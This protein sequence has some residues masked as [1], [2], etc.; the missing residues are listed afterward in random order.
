MV[1][2]EEAGI[3]FSVLLAYGIIQMVFIE[4]PTMRY[5]S[6]RLYL[7]MQFIAVLIV[8]SLIAYVSTFGIR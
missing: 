3:I 2:S 5:I 4:Y 1:I 8:V 7:S 6:P